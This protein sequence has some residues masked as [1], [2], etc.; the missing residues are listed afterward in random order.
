MTYL[1]TDSADIFLEC[2]ETITRRASHVLPARFWKRLA[3]RVC[4]ILGRTGRVAEWTRT[5][6][7]PWLVDTSPTAGVVLVGR[8]V[9]RQ[10][11]IDAEVTF[12]NSW[13]AERGTN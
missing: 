3:F 6:R 11:A 9:N 8:W 10:D 2:G 7:G 4:R 5:W 12:L 1:K 13:F